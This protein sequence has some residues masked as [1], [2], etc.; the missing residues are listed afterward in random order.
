MASRKVDKLPS[1][2]R[3]L[4]SVSEHLSRSSPDDITE[5]LQPDTMNAAVKS[6][7]SGRFRRTALTFFGVRKSICILPSFFGG[8]SKNPNKWSKKGI[9]KSRT[10]DGLSKVSHDD[11]LR[12]GYMSAADFEYHSQRDSAGELHSSCHNEC[13][14]PAA[15][16]QKSLTLT[17]Q[18]KGLRGLFHSFKYHRN[19]RN[20][21]LDK[22]EMIAMTSPHCK[23]EDPVVQDNASEYVTECLGSEPD[24]PDFADVI[25]D[26]SIGPECIDADV[27]ALEKSIEQ[28]SP[29][30][31]LSD[32][33][34]DD[35]M[36]EMNLVSVV[37]SDLEES[38]RGHSEPCLKLQTMSEPILKSETPAGSSDQLNLIFGDVASLKSFDSLT[39]CGDIIADQE[40]D[41]ITE[42]TVSGERSRNGGKRASCYLTYQGGGEEMASPEDLDEEECLHDMWRNNASEEICYSCNQEHTDLTADLT[43]SH[44]MDLVNSNSAQQAS[45]MDTS[46]IADVL[47]PQS[48]HQES[49]PNSDEGY[50]DSTTPGPEEGQEKADR[51][52]TDRLPRDSYS[53]DALY[54]LFAPDESL[55]SP[56]YENKSKLPSSNQ[57]EY[58]SEPVSV[59]DS[60]FVPG[61]NR[62]QIRAELYE[63]FLERPSVCSKSSE[64]AQ[65]VAGRQEIS[66]NK[67][68]N[69]NSKPQASVNKNNTEPDIFDEK[70]RMLAS[71]EQRT[72]SINSDL[73]KRHS[74]ISFGSTSDPDFETFC[75]PKEQHL[76]ENKPVALPYRNINSQSP[77]CSHDLDD[78]QTVSFSQALV[79]YTKHSQML[80]NL[81]NNAVDLESNSAFTP[82]MQALPTIVTFDVVDM[83]NEGEYDEQIHME[84]EEDIT[85]P[86]QE[87]EESYLQKDAFAECDYQMLDLYEQN[88]ISNTW[89]IASL[90]RHLGLTRVSQSM[91]NPLSLDRRSR[92]LDRE[93]LELK[94]P[95]TYRENRA[96]IV[97]CPQSEKDPERDSSPY[98]KKNVLVSASE[99]RD[100]S[101]IMALSWQTRSELALSLPLVDGEINDKL[102]G[103]SQTQVKH[104]VFSSSSSSDISGD[105]KH[106]CS[107]VSDRV[108][109]DT[110][111]QNTEL[112][113]RQCHLPLQSDSC[114]PH[115]TFYSGMMEQVSDDVDEDIF[116]KA[117]TN[118]QSYNQCGKSRPVASGREGLSHSGSPVKA[119]MSKEQMAVLNET[120]TAREVAACNK[121]P[122][123]TFN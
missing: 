32:Q 22:T 103:L 80:S 100:S 49:V 116:C 43:S 91:P 67:N 110:S 35:Q 10:H 24:V 58:L 99:V 92:S 111:P 62:L 101:S 53:G 31:E 27:I 90:P 33:M 60:S 12:S 106:L 64:S 18:K 95:D 118:L 82:N 68:C 36:E 26:I 28:E 71:P 84:L 108:S 113:N 78:G 66:P 15:A 75:E 29:K 115:G 88:L 114:S 65:N 73:E 86:Y 23:K 3:D 40:D 57:C 5:E 83:H 104:K 1:D 59:V 98:Y 63:D 122:D 25:C 121:L 37:S 44:N 54:E 85:S 2:S 6:Q 13:S 102:Q 96:A 17:R 42:S 46:S 50:Y 97:S 52:T 11:N 39:G 112:Y 69:L 105:G 9:T 107:N 7:K 74:S 21:G 77:D 34:C 79:D 41:S 81:Q 89:A 20:A 45:G 19:H 56:H 72:K 55:I 48:E 119:G 76:E 8:R 93:S 30:S 61:M 123:A 109:C 120:R 70:E 117:A 14:H 16:D 38:R 47:T 94:M 4:A 87:F 51:L